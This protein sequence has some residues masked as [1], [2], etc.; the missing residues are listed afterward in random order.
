MSENINT[1]LLSKLYPNCTIT[2]PWADHPTIYRVQ[3]TLNMFI[4][5]QD[6]GTDF[7]PLAVTVT[8]PICKVIFTTDEQE[9]LAENLQFLKEQF[10][11]YN[12]KTETDLSEA[13]FWAFTVQTTTP[14]WSTVL[15]FGLDWG[16]ARNTMCK[17]YSLKWGFQY[18]SIEKVHPLDRTILHNLIQEI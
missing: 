9:E 1:L 10:E 11:S 4:F 6:C 13:G 8:S 15:V 3:L 2:N 18:K 14:K 12:I 16:S 17:F 5:L 7:I